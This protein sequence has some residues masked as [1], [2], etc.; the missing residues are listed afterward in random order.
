MCFEQQEKESSELIM[1]LHDIKF[2]RNRN[3]KAGG[4][5]EENPHQK[6]HNFPLLRIKTIHMEKIPAKQLN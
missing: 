3:P 1:G 4:K 2:I 5:E 6:G